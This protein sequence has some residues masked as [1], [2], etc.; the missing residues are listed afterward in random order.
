MPNPGRE[1]PAGV[2]QYVWNGGQLVHERSRKIAPVLRGLVA[3][4]DL[5][6]IREA[7]EAEAEQEQG[8]ED[9]ERLDPRKRGVI[10]DAVVFGF[11]EGAMYGGVRFDPATYPSD[12]TVVD[13][14]LRDVQ[15][16]AH[17]YPALAAL[18]EHLGTGKKQPAP[19]ERERSAFQCATC[20]RDFEAEGHAT[21]PI[22]WGCADGKLTCP[23]CQPE[24][25]DLLEE[26]ERDEAEV[27]CTHGDPDKNRFQITETGDVLCDQCGEVVGSA[28]RPQPPA[29]A[30]EE[31]R[32]NLD[33]TKVE[34]AI[35]GEYSEEAGFTL[36]D[37]DSYPEWLIGAALKVV[38]LAEASAVEEA[39][40][41][42]IRDLEDQRERA[43]EE[44][45]DEC[46]ERREAAEAK[47]AAVRETCAANSQKEW[48]D[49]RVE[50]GNEDV[51]RR[52]R[53]RA[54]VYDHIRD[55]IDSTLPAVE[56]D[57]E[58][59][60]AKI[61]DAFKPSA[62]AFDMGG[63]HAQAVNWPEIVGLI[64]HYAAKLTTADDKE[65]ARG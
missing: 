63:G 5:P 20:P 28:G 44:G 41:D 38:D 4:S 39:A 48:A 13:R 34:E 50:G 23:N 22:D 37:G 65:A 59:L 60:V 26:G 21:V 36:T 9:C 54:T 32:R 8:G 64:L 3:V 17:L 57:R 55:Q 18:A 31:E 16:H 45:C 30:V 29:L 11:V 10:R 52:C 61:L 58:P 47:L 1:V 12:S 19:E 51:R 24:Q 49:S 25:P 15:S 14:V 40:K 27:M 35:W 33:L 6:R 53:I 56:E 7:W 43:G 46:E 62:A 2:E 42:R